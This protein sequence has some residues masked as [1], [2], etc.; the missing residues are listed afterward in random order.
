MEPVKKYYLDC[1][2]GLLSS[3]YQKG[4]ITELQRHPSPHIFCTTPLRLATLCNSNLIS[5]KHVKLLVLEEAGNID[6]Y[7][8]LYPYIHVYLNLNLYFV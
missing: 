3:P 6:I 7:T 5:L 4:D 1:T 2:I 8:S